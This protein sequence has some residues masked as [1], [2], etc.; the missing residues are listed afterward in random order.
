MVRLSDFS[1]MTDAM[2][3]LHGCGWGGYF[4]DEGSTSYIAVDEDR[5]CYVVLGVLDGQWGCEGCDPEDG[6]LVA[7]GYGD[8]AQEALDDYR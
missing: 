6:S 8:T 2:E 4:K 1:P 7:A 5:Q 3:R